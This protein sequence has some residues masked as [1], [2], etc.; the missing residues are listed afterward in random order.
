MDRVRQVP[1][2][3]HQSLRFIAGLVLAL[4]FAGAAVTSLAVTWL[5]AKH[6]FESGGSMD[7]FEAHLR[8][9]SDRMEVYDEGLRIHRARHPL[10][11]H[12]GMLAAVWVVTLASGMAIHRL[13]PPFLPG[14]E[15]A[16][17]SGVSDWP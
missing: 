9:Y 10:L 16:P 3:I 11:L 14:S 2:G 8:H 5:T 12:F 13:R 17:G 7:T 4:V 6:A 15:R 1:A